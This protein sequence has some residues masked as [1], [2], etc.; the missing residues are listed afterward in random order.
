MVDDTNFKGYESKDVVRA[1]IK[2]TMPRADVEA[3]MYAENFDF[4][5]VIKASEDTPYEV[6]WLT[7]DRKTSIHY[8]E[9]FDSDTRYVAI[10]G[11]RREEII[12]RLRQRLD[13]YEK[14]EIMAQ[15]KTAE[16]EDDAVGAI[17]I[18]GVSAPPAHD[19]ALLKFFER[20]LQDRRPRVR[21]A[22]IEAFLWASWDNC[23][24]LLNQVA[25][26]DDDPEIREYAGFA[27]Q[28]ISGQTERKS[29]D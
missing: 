10:K 19:K 24:T 17:V 27:I 25:A 15:Y 2:D 16:S 23:L 18:A 21:V 8:I 29:G 20:A 5:Q 7:P 28:A 1:V 14:D 6:V 26:H 4:W 9:D 3:V 12:D 13:V 11:E 22:V